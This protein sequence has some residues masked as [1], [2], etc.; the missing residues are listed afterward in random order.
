MRMKTSVELLYNC[1]GEYELPIC[2][3]KLAERLGKTLPE[4]T[5]TLTLRYK[6]NW[7]E[8][9]VYDNVV[10]GND[11]YNMEIRN[12]DFATITACINELETS[13]RL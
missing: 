6:K 7:I 8:A 2:L 10:Y 4:H 9:Y 12:K 11:N 1:M 3:W 13:G 5:I